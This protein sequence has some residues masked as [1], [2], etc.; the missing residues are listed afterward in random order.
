MLPTLLLR[1]V[2]L[3]GQL[4]NRYTLL[5]VICITL[6]ISLLSWLFVF[7]AMMML[8][9]FI[10]FTQQRTH[11]QQQAVASLA[12]TLA[13]ARSPASAVCPFCASCDCT[14]PIDLSTQT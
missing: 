10:P 4:S 11:Q 3:M 6:G 9:P 14:K 2:Q 13:I 1:P 8:M 5:Q 7:V 12:G